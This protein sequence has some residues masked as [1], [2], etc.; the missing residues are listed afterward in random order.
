MV[1]GGNGFSAAN[2]MNVSVLGSVCVATLIVMGSVPAKA[3]TQTGGRSAQWEPDCP[4][5]V[6]DQ[7]EQEVREELW[8][9]RKDAEPL[10]LFAGA[11]AWA[12]HDSSKATELYALAMVRR[13]YDLG[14]CVA[15]PGG[16]MSSVMAAVRMG[17]GQ[18]LLDVGIKV[19]PVEMRP[20]G[21]DPATYQYR[22]DHLGTV[23]EGAV[24]PVEAW[25][26]EQEKIRREIADRT[27]SPT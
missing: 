20:F 23:C 11:M 1:V 3:L 19:G 12:S 15:P 14:R 9:Q 16:M 26:R 17:A 24:K 21:L 5:Q 4:T 8:S 13:R 22:T 7:Y 2:K 27:K 25:P 6:A 18:A 10:C